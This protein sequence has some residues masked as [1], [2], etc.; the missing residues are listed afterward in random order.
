MAKS[1]VKKHSYAILC[2]IAIAVSIFFM[3]TAFSHSLLRV[4]EGL[5]ELWFGLVSFVQ[6]FFWIIPEASPIVPPADSA[7]PD[8]DINVLP[9]TP[10]EFRSNLSE[11]LN[12]L[13]CSQNM[14][15]YSI[16]LGQATEILTR[17]LM[18]V[19]PLWLVA[20]MLFKR[21]FS[22]INNNYNVDSKQLA[23]VKRV[24]E[25]TYVPTKN[26]IFGFIDYFDTSRFKKILLLIWLLNFNIFGIVATLFG[27]LLYFFVSL[28][29]AAIYHFVYKTVLDL[30]PAI[31]FMLH[32]LT[33]PIAVAIV[34]YKL[35]MW[36]KGRALAWLRRFEARNKGFIRERQIAFMFVGEMGL[37]KTTL[38]VDVSLSLE[39]WFRQ[40]AYDMMLEIDLKFPY[41]PW[42][43]LENEL[44]RAIKFGHVYNLR[45][46]EKWIKKKHNR[47]K[48]GGACFDYD[49][50]KYGLEYDSKKNIRHLFS[51]LSDYAKLYF[52]YIIKSSLIISNH[53]IR[54]DFIM[55]D[56]G[57]LP[58]WDLDF[59][60]R[61]AK[62]MHLH[63]RY[64]NVLHFDMLR[65]GFKVLKD[66]PYA[67]IF[68]FGIM[69]ITEIGKELGNQY[70]Q[71]E[72]TDLL[73]EIRA[74][75]KKLEKDYLDT[76]QERQRLR[77]Y[78]AY[79]YGKV[80]EAIK[81]IRHKATVAG[82]PFVRIV[83]DE[84][85]EQSLGADARELAE[86]VR[87][88]DKSEMRLAK[89]FFFIGELI[90]NFIHARFQR[91]YKQFRVNRGDNTL[92]MHTIKKV[93][94][95]NHQRYKHTYNRFGYRVIKLKVEKGRLDG[96]SVNRKY[97]LSNK[98]I[99]SDRF[100]TD[101]YSDMFSERMDST[102]K[103]INDLPKYTS[104]KAT[105][106]QLMWQGSN[107]ITE[108]TQEHSEEQH[109]KNAK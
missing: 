1:F 50:K 11:F 96:W 106:D 29:V 28:D 26:Y 95:I 23:L 67:E 17:V 13:I 90:Y 97:Y 36:R 37:G 69:S 64:S 52:I 71:K 2:V 89:P 9:D 105:E 60:N 5:R 40:T 84:Q 91:L 59:F 68:E 12:L 8:Q 76:S 18:L 7:T 22:R 83:M 88:E 39:A 99:Y 19:I 32:P 70:K 61:S 65:L 63:S 73:K 54:T 44:K 21:H 92:L 25:Q 43:N 6:F 15:R 56:E 57:N 42:I 46:V 77:Q 75:V 24:S 85:R 41:F 107:F 14:A 33:V 100:A 80:T 10:E 87:I 49:Y 4:L 108:I 74:T 98:K 82:F 72:I 102:T 34:Y 78:L 66:N 53:A 3:L 58:E 62:R 103:G 104:H 55:D 31:R 79:L 35:D 81:L 51:E 20:N 16:V 48:K 27:F 93:G 38:K 101:A 30:M 94:A 86:I 47:F 45:T 109:F